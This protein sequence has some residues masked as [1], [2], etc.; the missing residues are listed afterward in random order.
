MKELKYRTRDVIESLQK[1]RDEFKKNYDNALF[2]YNEEKRR[3]IYKL[4][5]DIKLEIDTDVPSN[6]GL[7]RPIDMT[8][9]YDMIISRYERTED[10]FV[11]LSNP[12]FEMIFFDK[13][14][15]VIGAK[16]LNA[17]YFR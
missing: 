11:Y 8:E 5:D 2:V 9:K 12:E 4:V 17:T 3:R 13:W 15:W 10:E 7:V 14:D 1:N 6:L 16:A